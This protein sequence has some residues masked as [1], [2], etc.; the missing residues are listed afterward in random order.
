MSIKALTIHPDV[1]SNVTVEAGQPIRGIVKLTLS[2]PVPDIRVSVAFHGE[3][4]ATWLENDDP[5]RP[6][7]L[8]PKPMISEAVTVFDSTVK[9][10]GG[11]L[12]AGTHTLPFV[13]QTERMGIRKLN[14]RNLPP[15]YTYDGSAGSNVEKAYGGSASI[16]YSLRAS[17]SH[18]AGFLTSKR[19]ST[20]TNVEVI[21]TQPGRASRLLFPFPF[22]T[23]NVVAPG[24][25]RRE[26]WPIALRTVDSGEVRWNLSMSRRACLPGDG[27]ECV[28]IAQSV[29]KKSIAR[30]TLSLRETTTFQTMLQV[31]NLSNPAT[32]E[33][34]AVR[35]HNWSTGLSP[36]MSSAP[37]VRSMNLQVPRDAAPTMRTQILGNTHVVRL[38][39]E[40][41]GEERPCTV[42]EVPLDIVMPD[43]G[44]GGREFVP[45]LARDDSLEFTKNRLIKK[46]AMKERADSAL[47]DIE[48]PSS[49]EGEGKE[50]VVKHME[51]D[52]GEGG[53]ERSENE[54]K[55]A[56][57]GETPSVIQ[58]R[59]KALYAY[60]PNR[61]DEIAVGENDVV[62]IR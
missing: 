32:R 18:S 13:I 54:I 33:L 24:S 7:T 61:P 17:A 50:N 9:G 19:V 34:H 4:E 43:S 10:K 57:L 27:I 58:G 60:L 28:V 53:M 46:K 55:V 12:P 2:K 3:K 26:L 16:R 35:E 36:E 39:V 38:V 11:I 41:D 49:Q 52:E 37:I 59:F 5:T 29:V 25:P 48:D 30:V 45:E 56:L 42:V 44:N 31:V 22:V 23:G 47:G 21:V 1:G 20:T 40:L 51:V 15:T 6:Y 14:L 8:S 62:Q